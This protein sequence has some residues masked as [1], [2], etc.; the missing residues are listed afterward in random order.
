VVYKMNAS[1]VERE[2]PSL[3]LVESPYSFYERV[4]EQGGVYQVPGTNEYLVTRYE[5]AVD[6]LLHPEVFSSAVQQVLDRDG[7]FA[8]LHQDGDVHR[9]WRTLAVRPFSPE[10]MR[11]Y[12]PKIRA[13]VDELIDAFIDRGHANFIDEFATPLPI[14]VICE[15]FGLPRSDYEKLKWWAQID[16]MGRRY[17]SP[18]RQAVER[19]RNAE[20]SAYLTELVQDRYANPGDD[21][22]SELIQAFVSRDGELDMRVLVGTATTFLLGGIVTSAH[23]LGSTMGV[24]LNHPTELERVTRDH[25]LVPGLVEESLRVESPVQWQPRVTVCDTEID[26]VSIPA[27]SLVLV[28]LASANRDERTFACPGQFQVD[29]PNARKHVAFSMGRHLCIG[30]PLARMEGV[31]GFSGLLSR[32]RNIRRVSDAQDTLVDN[33]TFRGLEQLEIEFEPM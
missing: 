3:A 14:F 13:I 28:L 1:A 8:G 31:V 7:H 29:R 33:L 22:I 27:Q 5:D 19:K 9:S 2:Y 26:G 32:L 4:R 21:I 23:M 17:Y 16:G 24:L 11:I 15:L 25:S 12:E 30:A 20:T 10:R 6:V 18:E